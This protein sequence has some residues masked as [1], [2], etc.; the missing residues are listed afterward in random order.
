[1]SL[2]LSMEKFE[3]DTS[4]NCVSTV[5]KRERDPKVNISLKT[6][7]GSSVCATASAALADTS[8]IFPITPS[9][10]IAQEVDELAAT[11]YKNYA[12]QSI[13]V[14]TL[15]SEAGAAGT[16]EGLAST[17]TIA[18]TF[19]ASQGLFL[20]IPVLYKLSGNLLPAVINVANRTIATNSL[21]IF[22]DLSDITACL[23]SGV[24]ILVA[25]SV[26]A[27][28]HNTL[29]AFMS[30][31][32]A[33][34]PFINT[35]DGFRISHANTT[36]EMLSREDMISL[37]DDEIMP[38]IDAH[39]MRGLDPSKPVMQGTAMTGDT[40]FQV[41]EAAN[42]FHAAVP[43]IVEY[44]YEKLATK[45][46][47]RY[48][49]FDYLG[50]P[51]ATDVMIIMGSGAKV[52]EEAAAWLIENEDRK[53]GVVNVRL[54]RPFS[55]SHFL[56][57]LPESVERIVVM[58]RV[59]DANGVG[60]PLFVD[61]A[62]AL[63][64]GNRN[65]IKV[66]GGR[67][68]LSS[69]DFTPMH[70]RS[71]F[72][73]LAA[74]T[75]I[76]SFT[77]GIIDDVTHLSLPK[78]PITFDTLPKDCIQA[79]FYGLGGDGT[80]GANKQAV[81]IAAQYGGFYSQGYY[82]YDSIK[83]GSFTCSH[84]RLSKQQI[85]SP[86]Y[87]SLA[88]YVACH[89]PSY[90]NRFALLRNA[91]QNADFVLNCSW[92]TL[93]EFNLH[94]PA[95]I[96]HA[97]AEK[98]VNLYVIDAT[99]IADEAGMPGRINMAMQTVFFKIAAIFPDM[100]EAISHLK[101]FINKTYGKKGRE[102]VEKNFAMVD[103]TNEE[104]RIIKLD[105]PRDEWLSL[106]GSQLT[107]KHVVME[108]TE[109]IEDI[110]DPFF[111]NEGTDIPVSKFT[112]GG[113]LEMNTTAYS[114]RGIAIR[115]PQ[116]D[117]EKCVQCNSCAF[118]CPHSVI[119]P[120]YLNEE[121]EQNKPSSMNTLDAKGKGMDNLKF[122]IQI[123]PL[124]CTGCGSCAEVCKKVVK[125]DAL[126]MEPF[127]EE[128]EQESD[129]WR[130]VKS[131]VPPKP[132]LMLPKSP[133]GV[134]L[135]EYAYQFSGACAGCG[136]APY[137]KLMLQMA[138]YSIVAQATGCGT[139][140]SSSYPLNAHCCNE[141]GEGP[142]WA[143]SLFENN[144]EFGYGMIIA[145]KHRREGLMMRV[146]EAVLNISMPDAML[147]AFNEWLSIWNNRKATEKMYEK[148]LY[149]L[150]HYR[151]V[152]NANPALK[153]IDID[154]GLF[155]KP[156]HLIMGGDGWAYDIGY[157]G[158]DQVLASGEDFVV[159]VADTEV[160][161]NTGGQMS[162]ASHLSAQHKF[163][164]GG[165]PTFKK[166]LGLMAMQ[167][168][169]VYVA[170]CAM[171]ASPAQF[172]RRAQEALD[173]EGPSLLVCSS[174]CIEWNIKG[175]MTQS[176]LIQ[177][178]AV[179]TG[180]WINWCYNP[181]LEDKNK[182]PFKID[183][184]APS[185][186]PELFLQA[187]GRFRNLALKF[188]E[189]AAELQGQLK[190]Y[191]KKRY[192]R[193]TKLIKAYEPDEEEVEVAAPKVTIAYASA[194]G[195]TEG[196]ARTLA[197]ELKADIVE[198]SAL[199]IAKLKAIKHPVIFL[200]S[201]YTV[202]TP[203]DIPENG[204]ALFDE[205]QAC[206]TEGALSGL[207]FALYGFGDE[208]YETFQRAPGIMW[209]RL[210]AL[211]ATNIMPR[212][213]GNETDGYDET[214]NAFKTSLMAALG[215]APAP[216]AKPVKKAPVKK[217]PVKKVA[218]QKPVV[219]AAPKAEIAVNDAPVAEIEG[220][221]E[222]VAKGVP[223][224]E[225]FD[226]DVV[227]TGVVDWNVRS[228][229]GY[230]ARN[231]SA[232]NAFL[233]RDEQSFLVD[234]VKAS[235]ADEFIKRIETAMPLEEI[236]YII[237]NHA[238]PD[239]TSALPELMK[240]APHLKIITNRPC[241]M[242]LKRLFAHHG[243][244]DW[245]YEL[246]KDGETRTFGRHTVKFITTPLLHWP[247]SMMT[248]ME[249]TGI[250]FSMD[251]FGQHRACSARIDDQLGAPSMDEHIM[252]QKLYW[253]NILMCFEAQARSAMKKIA[254]IMSDVKIIATA[255]GVAVRKYIPIVMDLYD[256]WINHGTDKKVLIVYDTM[257]Q[258]ARR[259][260][261]AI[262]KGVNESG[263]YAV[264]MNAASSHYTYIATEALEAGAIALGTS[265]LNGGIMPTMAAASEYLGGLQRNFKRKGIAFSTFG[266]QPKPDHLER[267]A[268]MAKI[269][270]VDTLMVRLHPDDSNLEA[271]FEA[272]VK[273]AQ[274]ALEQ[275]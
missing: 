99:K 199:N 84:V 194:T 202:R 153:S 146:Q 167:Y 165:K 127:E 117:A 203:G 65:N 96:R 2:S 244:N 112:P 204:A 115:V 210:T 208:A 180:F 100:N 85:F 219:T 131:S 254:P 93:D 200:N 74:E 57:A 103:M 222:W 22:G 230:E 151:D 207:K 38:F 62:T 10:P 95:A 270:L 37:Y 113:L 170:Y 159:L 193:Y 86:Y 158:L 216:V 109:F 101:E 173:F 12:N 224:N 82:Q 40:F 92:T 64:M 220:I 140:I 47:I 272:G 184:K 71:A 245:E 123:S 247:D 192:K 76:H 217:A 21:S 97:I 182:N 234:A 89:Q 104:G 213:I 275:Q 232:Y 56:N 156:V 206:E 13:K 201:S 190:T 189:Q 235:F 171:G 27:T 196:Y 177:K 160:Y 214:F 133:K 5:E 231:G 268:E 252:D 73:N 75:P 240:K 179:D 48:H 49:I 243:S 134:T 7:S 80:V 267:M 46:G 50:H 223:R 227:W 26:Q 32:V 271:C 24:S 178:L 144:A 163:S 239:H 20:M 205:L 52:A 126:S 41:T 39:R 63:K 15:E 209:D 174:P 51:A 69:A 11:G 249:T 169:N 105:Y 236:K 135:Q 98:N 273:L 4:K 42:K 108:K 18:T 54:W 218:V 187:N 79:V 198:Y 118:V 66:V 148:V 253:A 78:C 129:H 176:Q 116:W 81:K 269:D 147:E 77:V 45:T 274:I 139:I 141:K 19:T 242:A 30:S 106:S 195:T 111:R 83:A 53:V 34:L 130:Y 197:E 248:F 263:C 168:G 107:N 162:K 229:H 233:V 212:G 237:M 88:N 256:K 137:W 266:W 9:T 228:F 172:V 28:H 1:M 238:E 143:N 215:S 121:Q 29:I 142:A 164:Y 122:R 261:E 110:F 161:S 166:E 90:V 264:L 185:K 31:L 262:A 70:V 211:G 175:G 6:V 157:G 188:P 191:L 128:V 35:F 67:F 221:E 16:I 17:G 61:V 14:V 255:H 246:V 72:D 87:V 225:V 43:G 3:F 183:S 94:V 91:R 119:R 120:F 150:D 23:H 58:D 258:G 60:E 124:D 241:K 259:M 265:R 260:A 33:R 250:L 155:R 44:M 36:I 138:P 55:V 59:R 152:V 132:E 186:D 25:D 68:G 8:G 251:A 149:A 136:E 114:K 181:T 145:T 257:W 154:R 102:I 226:T 125:A